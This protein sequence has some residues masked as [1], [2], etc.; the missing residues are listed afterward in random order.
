MKALGAG[1]KAGD[2]TGDQDASG[3]AGAHLAANLLDEV[4]GA[5]N[6]GVDDAADIGEVL[7]QEGM[8][9]PV[10][11]VGENGIDGAA[12]QRGAD[13]VITFQ[14][15]EV[16]LDSID[17]GAEGAELIGGLLDLRLVS[18]DDQVES[19]P[20]TAFGQFIADTGRSAGDDG[21]R[22]SV[23]LHDW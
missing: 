23:R 11:C 8:A 5:G 18:G 7:I 21:E 20:G 1:H 12:V 10:T 17:L 3:T 6:V 14:C 13:L 9:Q 2:G 19:F 22:S 15:G 4:G 16:G